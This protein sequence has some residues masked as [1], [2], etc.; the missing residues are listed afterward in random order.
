M[1]LTA[2][3]KVLPLPLSPTPHALAAI[4]IYNITSDQAMQ[5]IQ[6]QKKVIKSPNKE[7]IIYLRVLK[8][9][10]LDPSCLKTYKSTPTSLK[11]TKY[12]HFCEKNH[13]RQVNLAAILKNGSHLGFSNGQSGRFVKYPLVNHH[14]KFGACITICTILLQNC[15]YL[16]HYIVF[17]VGLYI[18]WR[19]DFT[20]F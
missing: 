5:P 7:K 17:V 6:N 3:T 16:P 9:E 2:E 11:S 4:A 8:L 10:K 1:W 19:V 12:M 18:R 20:G 14:A 13:L 15:C